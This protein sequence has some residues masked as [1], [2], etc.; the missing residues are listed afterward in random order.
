M[1]DGVHVDGRSFQM[2]T[3]VDGYRK[4]CSNHSTPYGGTLKSYL[5]EKGLQIFSK[6]CPPEIIIDMCTLQSDHNLPPLH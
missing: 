6:K 4:L 1:R 2:K 5:Y 3:I